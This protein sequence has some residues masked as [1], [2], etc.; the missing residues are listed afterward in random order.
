MSVLACCWIIRM[1]GSFA[2]TQVRGFCWYCCCCC[3]WLMVSVPA[4]GRIV[5]K[6]LRS[7]YGE[8]CLVG[9]TC[10]VVAQVMLYY[11]CCC[12][13][14]LY[15]WCC[16]CEPSSVHYI[17]QLSTYPRVF[18]RVFSHA[19]QAVF[20][21]CPLSISLVLRK[22]QFSALFNPEMPIDVLQRQPLHNA[23]NFQTLM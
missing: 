22:C 17:F 21:R 4:S 10:V 13:C 20:Y 18:S 16:C 8:G 23:R 9:F 6:G 11:F 12:S 19:A 2:H 1:F 7:S 15:C 3:C 14:I 5:G